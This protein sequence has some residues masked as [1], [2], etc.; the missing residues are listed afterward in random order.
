[1]FLQRIC[2]ED[3]RIKA[4]KQWPEPKL[5]RDIQVFLRFANFYWQFIQGYS[6]I[7]A[8]LTLILKITGNI[9]SATNSKEIEGKV[10]GNKVDGDNLNSGG[11]TTNQS[12]SIKKNQAKI[13]K[14]KILVKSKNH[15][16][17]LNSRNRKAE[18]GFFTSK[19]RLAFTQ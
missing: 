11:E 16:V 9:G 5:V 10:N 1:M 3:E 18:T 8:P 15:D 4:V 19:A 6:C 14:S 13:T 2:I 7:A 17:S 12:N